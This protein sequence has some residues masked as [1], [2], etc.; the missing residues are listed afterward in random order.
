MPEYVLTLLVVAVVLAVT[1]VLGRL[2]VRVG[3][4]FRGRGAPRGD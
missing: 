1:F 3:A 4:R 2:A